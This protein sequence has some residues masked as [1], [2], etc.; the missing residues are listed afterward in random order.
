MVPR[1]HASLP[2]SFA[3]T[4]RPALQGKN[5][6]KPTRLP[7]RPAGDGE[8]EQTERPFHSTEFEKEPPQEDQSGHNALRPH[9]ALRPAPTRGIAPSVVQNTAEPGP[10]RIA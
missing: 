10:L 2:R 4:P 5:T 6:N 7:P 8:T 1:R 9:G 3:D